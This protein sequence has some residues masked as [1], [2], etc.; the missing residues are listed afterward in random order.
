MAELHGL[1]CDRIARHAVTFAVVLGTLAGRVLDTTTGQPLAHVGV[2]SGT[3]HATSDA[4]GRF[5]LHGLHRG[6]VIVTL[7]SSD[8]PMQRVTVHVGSGLVHHDLRACSTTLDYS[9]TKG[10]S[11]AGG[12]SG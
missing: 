3:S 11:S 12:G 10:P 9:C 4:R 5:A 8:V 2:V 7:E 6:N 1:G